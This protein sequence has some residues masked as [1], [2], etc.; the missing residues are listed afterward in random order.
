M[1]PL[2]RR[3]RWLVERRRK[4]TELRDELQFH[5]EEEAEER[6]AEGQARDEARHAARR[7]LGNVTLVQEDTRAMWG[8]TILEQL[9]QDL[10]YAFRTMAASRLFTL[11]AVATLALGIGANTAIYSFLDSIL[12]R[13]LPVPDPQSLVVLNWHAKG[14]YRDWRDFVMHGGSGR[15]YDDPKLG[16]TAGIFPYPAFELLRKHNAVFSTAFVYYPSWQ[17]RNLNLAV[18]GEAGLANGVYVSGDYF[19]GLGIAPAA[20]RL[21]D[22]DDD[23]P[24]ASAVA[25]I[26]YALSQSRFGGSAGA[27]GRAI[28]IDNVP[29]TVVGVTPPGFFG[30]DPAEAPEIYLPMHTDESLGAGRPFG[31]L[32]RRYLEP[33]DYWIH[34]MGRLRPGVSL[35]QAQ[36]VLA[37]A[38]HEWVAGT[39]AN[40]RERANLPALIVKEGAGGLDSL[41]RQYSRPLYVL[42]TMV[43]LILALACI[44]VANLLLARAAARRR[45]IA[46]RLSVGASRARVVRQ[47]LTESLLLAT[48]GGVIGVLFAFWG[49]RFLTVLL[50]NGQ[51]SFTLHAQLNWHVLGAAAVLSLLTGVLFGMVPALQA[52]RVD[53]MPAL[54]ETQT[55]QPRTHSFPRFGLARLLVVSQ[56]AISLLLLVAAG[57]FV[58]TLAN[59]HAVDLG[60]NREHVLLFRLDARKAG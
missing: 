14:L 27:A 17:A 24:G 5:L 56:I 41:R 2:F 50:A 8:W 59:L 32:G 3:I 42:M 57:L 39:A 10:R 55:G 43:A 47:L 54:K 51:A 44:N 18:K 4:D 20:G 7:D 58:R 6:Q 22:P 60:F 49:I 38:F 48:L 26:S 15:L 34:I 35:A 13:S 16:T 9:G 28:Q 45:E 53:V 46:L 29:F 30:V 19:R 31:F 37:P 1:R 33:N 40:D 36:A 52:T 23:R 25:V 21:I 11:L 12:L